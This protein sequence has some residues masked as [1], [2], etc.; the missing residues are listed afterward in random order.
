MDI[1]WSNLSTP[2]IQW[3]Y[4][5]IIGGFGNGVSS[6]WWH[7]STLPVPWMVDKTNTSLLS[8]Q[9]TASKLE[10]LKGEFI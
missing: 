2:L 9:C 8:Y 1:S 7:T 4:S 3:L 5:S 6:P 10:V